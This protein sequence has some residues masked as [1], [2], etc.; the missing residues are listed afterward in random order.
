[1]TK[2]QLE[3]SKQYDSI[4]VN[5][6]IKEFTDKLLNIYSKKRN[7]DIKIVRDRTNKFTVFSHFI[8]YL[9]ALNL[10]KNTNPDINFDYKKY[11]KDRLTDID[12]L[13]Y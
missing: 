5:K 10:D 13:L 12:I 2:Q 8:W 1:V 6:Y 9:W 11:A 4:Y 7:I 3:D